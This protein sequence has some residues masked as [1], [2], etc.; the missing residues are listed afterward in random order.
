MY[1][2]SDLNTCLLHFFIFTFLLTFYF[3]QEHIEEQSVN[4]ME[5]MLSWIEDERILEDEDSSEVYVALL[6]YLGG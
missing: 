2:K 5:M 1:C 6:E 3:T 4:L